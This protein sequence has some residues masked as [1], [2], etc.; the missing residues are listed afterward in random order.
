MDVSKNSVKELV[1]PGNYGLQNLQMNADSQLQ[2]EHHHG[3]RPEQCLQVVWQF[4]S[5]S[6]T[7]IHGDVHSAGGNLKRSRLLGLAGDHQV[8]TNCYNMFSAFLV[9]MIVF[10][11]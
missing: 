3:T 4:G 2:S 1:K 5:P 11:D 6:I 8:S 7:W 9:P 10:I